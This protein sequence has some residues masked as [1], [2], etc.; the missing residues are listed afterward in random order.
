MK[1]WVIT[2]TS[3][4]AAKKEP[5]GT[6]VIAMLTARKNTDF[7]KHYIECLCY[8]YCLDLDGQKAAAKYTN[9]VPTVKADGEGNSD[10]YCYSVNVR[11]RA[12]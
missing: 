11:P 7:I 6:R 3:L 12:S 4:E 2:V 1:A 9:P 10:V 5:C 8:I